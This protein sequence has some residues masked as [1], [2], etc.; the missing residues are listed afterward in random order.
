[1]A[2]IS[3]TA[4]LII[5]FV[6]LF[7][8]ACSEVAQETSDVLR[9]VNLYTVGHHSSGDIRRFPAVVEATQTADLTFR[10]GG[11]IH[12][13]PWRPG[14]AVNQG[15]LIAALD[16]TDYELTVAQA[17]ARAELAEAQFRRLERLLDQNI[18]SASQFDEARAEVQVARAN[19]NTAKANLGYTRLTA[20]F[21]GV[22][23]NLHVELYENIGPQQPVVTLHVDDMI[24]VSIQ[25][26]ER[27]FAQVR[28]ETQYQPD[29]VFDS[30][31]DTIFKGQLRQWDRI[32]DPAT[33]TYRVVFTLPTP[34]NGNILPGMTASVIIDSQQVLPQQQ[35]TVRVPISAVFVPPNSPLQHQERMVWVYQSENGDSGILE[36]RRVTIGPASSSDILIV[37]GLQQGEQVVIAGVHQLHEGQR[38]RPWVRERGL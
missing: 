38:V 14:Q 26:P 27:L 8:S 36:Q 17:Q 5:P 18:I 2:H 3:R 24:D 22:I 4:L 12:E 23:A 30:M 31:P 37:A 20:P 1:M 9:P 29:I 34:K 33:N 10:V 7:V 32:A 16:P 28:R 11:E 13:L 25:V 19:L 6:A 15:D 35:D 21:A